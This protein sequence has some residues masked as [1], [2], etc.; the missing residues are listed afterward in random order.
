M[1]TE[2]IWNALFAHAECPEE[3][4]IINYLNVNIGQAQFKAKNEWDNLYMYLFQDP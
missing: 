1:W 3:G 2:Q 4:Y